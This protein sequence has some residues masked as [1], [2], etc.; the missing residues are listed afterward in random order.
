MKLYRLSDEG[1]QILLNDIEDNLPYYSSETT[2]DWV[3]EK[4]GSIENFFIEI[5]NPSISSIP[6]LKLTDCSRQEANYKNCLTVYKSLGFAPEL[7]ADFQFWAGLSHSNDFYP[8]VRSELN[9]NFKNSEP[10][11]QVRLIRNAFF[12]RENGE[13]RAL[14]TNRLSRLWWIPYAIDTKYESL[15]NNLNVLCSFGLMET[16]NDWIN[17][18]TYSNSKKVMQAIINSVKKFTN[19]HGSLSSRSHIRPALNALNANSGGILIDYLGL[20]ELESKFYNLLEQGFN[21]RLNALNLDNSPDDESDYFEEPYSQSE[22]ENENNPSNQRIQRTDE[23][24][25]PE[26][27]NELLSFEKAENNLDEPASISNKSQDITD[28]RSNTEKNITQQSVEPLAKKIP[29]TVHPSITLS[30]IHSDTVKDTFSPAAVFTPVL[31]GMKVQY[32]SKIKLGCQETGKTDEYTFKRHGFSG[33]PPII[34]NLNGKEAGYNFKFNNANYV[35]IE[36]I[37]G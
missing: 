9:V 24:N 3:I 2:A 5:D 32:Y 28:D 17:N 36:V 27:V 4:Y 11:K 15:E 30:E 22:S 8:Y 13:R 34:A 19:K 14:L 25:K 6:L 31:N 35:I 10:E 18:R 21:E 12:K 1:Y 23:L 16:A 7:A 29:Q 20:Q 37:N 33:I 26:L